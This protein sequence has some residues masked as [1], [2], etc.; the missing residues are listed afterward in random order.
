MVV[1]GFF[2]LCGFGFVICPM[3]TGI[4][5]DAEALLA[6]VSLFLSAISLNVIPSCESLPACV[7]F[8][9]AAEKHTHFLSLS[10]ES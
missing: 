9:I 5:V 6:T 3:H 8:N 4:L 2:V 7:T 1:T 10:L